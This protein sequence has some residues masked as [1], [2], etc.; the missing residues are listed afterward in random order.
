MSEPTDPS[1]PAP[2]PSP[3]PVDAIPVATV[4]QPRYSPPQPVTP[5]LRGGRYERPGIITAIGVVSIV[6]AS[7]SIVG[8]GI[9]GLYAFGFYMAAQWSQAMNRTSNTSATATTTVI[10]LDGDEVGLNGLAEADRRLVGRAVEQLH[11]LTPTRQKVFD[12]L[13]AHSGAVIFPGVD[14]SDESLSLREIKEMVTEE[15]VLPSAQSGVAGADFLVTQAGRIEVYDTHAVFYPADGGPSTS[16]TADG[17]V[18]EAPLVLTPA[19][20]DAMIDKQQKIY[21]VKL[22]PAQRT[23]VH[24]LLEDPNQPFITR[25]AG[26]PADQLSALYA[27]DD[28]QVVVS[29]TNGTAWIDASGKVTQ[30]FTN[31]GGGF[32]GAAGGGMSINLGAFSTVLVGVALSV[33][34]ALFLLTVGIFTLRQSLRARGLHLIY[35]GIK[36]PV[37]ALLAFGWYK[38]IRSTGDMNNDVPGMAPGVAAMILVLGLLY[39]IALLIVMNVRSVR[40]YYAAGRG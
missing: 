37:A 18:T 13:L 16:V 8:G 30:Q 11:P 10:N 17:T 12:R 22:T 36:I 27:M 3:Q 21:S 38:L 4:Y 29:F 24:E 23:A 33:A 2:P 14:E 5:P 6:I 32:G 39:P 20:I 1:I 31:T 26:E 34:L 15:G 40:E 9:S 25:D 19:V 7:L 28:G 35:A